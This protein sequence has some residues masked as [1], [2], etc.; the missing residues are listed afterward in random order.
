MAKIGTL[1]LDLVAN[2]SKWNEG[3]NAAHEKM[4]KLRDGV[5]KFGPAIAKAIGAGVGAAAGALAVMVK[6]SADAAREIDAFTRSSKV[7]AEVLQ[8]WDFAG[9]TVGVDKV[10]DV[11][12]DVSDRV[13]EFL[14]TGAGPM[15]DW[16]N[17]IGKQA[18]LTAK[19]FANLSGDQALQ[20]FVTVSQAAGANMDQ[21]S[22]MMQVISAGSER[23]LPLLINGGA[24]LKKLTDEATALGMVLSDKEVFQLKGL[25]TSIT[26]ATGLFSSMS[27]H[28][29]ATLAPVLD[30]VI[31]MFT[32]MAKEA[33][34]MGSLADKV[35]DNLVHG[36]MFVAD[37]IDGAKRVGS[38]TW[39]VLKAGVLAVEAIVLNLANIIQGTLL[40]ALA[41]VAGFAAKFSMPGAQEA[42]DFLNG[43]AT[44]LD[45]LT[46]SVTQ[47]AADAANSVR[48]AVSNALNKPMPSTLLQGYIDKA[49]AASAASF[50]AQP[51]ATGVAQT[52][53]S[54]GQQQG[55]APANPA[56]DPR[57][58][59]LVAFG[60]TKQQVLQEQY[61]AENQLI[62]DQ[63]KSHAITEAQAQKASL[64]AQQK[65]QK[66]MTDI[67]SEQFAKRTAAA[68][69][70][71][72]N[73]STLMNS[74]N[75]EMFEVGKAAAI[76]QT[77][78]STYEGA[79]KAFTSFSGL[80]PLG[81]AAGIAAATAAVAAGMARVKSIESTEFGGGS[82][83]VSNTE[84]VNSAATPTSGGG[85]G[86]SRNVF[87]HVD[88]PDGIVRAGTLVDQLNI[89]LGDGK[90][91]VNQ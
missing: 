23:M 90:R 74:K 54:F 60:Q 85:A 81:V 10:G 51:A 12:K 61:M 19:D 52:G 86:S 76:T 83:G 11:F 24:G 68:N 40:T 48:T 55:A 8:K 72:S 25:S 46:A 79:Q 37:S 57:I 43:M 34:G 47:Q 66:A 73:L 42:A 65:Y 44:G 29:S 91:L 30:A 36:F 7:S 89:E 21:L 38:V 2:A 64:G 20:K 27:K 67:S 58:A 84:A 39:A 14:T 69:T 22:H 59:Q 87:I 6:T 26:K 62:A 18:G 32:D 4:N 28:I 49:N 33:G 70:A 5:N 13:G 1:T 9:A 77:I 3:F 53:V 78:I 88:N 17:T 15:S 80:G 63:L 45:T 35:V 50:A 75:R 16:F 71:L 82:A 56:A 31:K 41:K